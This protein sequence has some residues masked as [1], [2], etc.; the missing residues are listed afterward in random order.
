ML[1]NIP[2]TFTPDLLKLMM[3]LGHG[4]ELLI[5]DANYPARTSGGISIPRIYVPVSDI[6]VLLMDI[7]RFFPL[8]YAVEKP[9]L[10]MEIALQSGAYDKYERIFAETEGSGKIETIDRFG[11]Y[12]RVEKAAGIVIS[13][14]ITAGANILLKKGV[15]R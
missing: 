8:D 2:F 13:S 5:S 3:E 9:A 7:L 12:A 10:V 6:G 14:D 15:V 11:F 4:E 1:K